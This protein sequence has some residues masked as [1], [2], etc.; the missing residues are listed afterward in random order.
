M[1]S[2]MSKE[3]ESLHSQ[4]KGWK[5]RHDNRASKSQKTISVYFESLY[6]IKLENGKGYISRFAK[7]K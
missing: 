2:Q 6:F 4:S 5:G 1:F 3:S 7:I